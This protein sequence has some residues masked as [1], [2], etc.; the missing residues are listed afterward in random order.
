MSTPASCSLTAILSD[1][2]P[3]GVIARRGPSR[4]CCIIRWDLARDRFEIGQWYKGRVQLEALSPSGEWMLTTCSKGYDVWSVLSKPP[5]LTAHGLWHIGD[6]W[7]AGGAFLS[8]RRLAL[9]RVGPVPAEE[10]IGK[11]RLPSSFE[12]L[13]HPPRETAPPPGAHGWQARPGTRWSTKPEIRSDFAC[14]WTKQGPGGLT[15]ERNQN[16]AMRLMGVDGSLIA[17]L[18]ARLGFADFNTFGKMPGLVFAIGGRLFA[19]P[20]RGI[21][22]MADEAALVAAA[23]EIADFSPLTFEAKVAPA[24]HLPAPS[25]LRRDGGGSEWDPLRGE[26][27]RRR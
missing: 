10:N 21:V 6:H 8:D 4:Q 19:I 22:P 11:A 16:G 1:L 20:A 23:R 17:D 18:P 9:H 15:L 26:P 13:Q 25:L 14:G 3:V 7:G 12:V 2:A 27:A 5:Y 24:S